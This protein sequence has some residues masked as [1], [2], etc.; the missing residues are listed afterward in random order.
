MTDYWL[1]R[2]LCVGFVSG[3]VFME[4]HRCFVFDVGILMNSVLKNGLQW[5]VLCAV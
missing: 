3:L 5:C 1:G 4:E 2:K